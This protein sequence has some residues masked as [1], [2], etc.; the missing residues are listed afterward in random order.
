MKPSR[1]RSFSRGDRGRLALD[2]TSGN[3][4]VVYYDTINDPGRLKTDIWM[5][6]SRDGGITWRPGRQVTSAEPN[7]TGTSADPNQYGD[8][9]GLTSYTGRYFDSWTDNRNGIA[10][11]WGPA[12]V[13]GF[14]NIAYLFPLLTG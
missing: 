8:Y 10:E 7:E 6:A 1:V 5:Q 4:M 11:I 3:L 2:D 12:I 9:I 13:S 14:A